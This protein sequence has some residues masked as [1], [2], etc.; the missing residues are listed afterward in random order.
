MRPRTPHP[1]DAEEVGRALSA[2]LACLFSSLAL[3]PLAGAQ[4]TVPRS[5]SA[6][7]DS[8]G[9]TTHIVYFDTSYG[10]WPRVVSV[11]ADLGIRHLRDGVYANPAPQWRD[12][13]QRYY[14][15]VEL[16][17]ARGLRFDFGMGQ[18]GFQ[19]GTLRQLVAVVAGRLRNAV[20]ALEDPNEFD[21][22]GGTAH[23]PSALAAY[24]RALY[25]RVKSVPSLRSLPVVGPSFALPA[26]PSLIGNQSPW[27]DVGNIHPYT[28][29]LP[30]SLA[31]TASEL[32]R[33]G[34]T[35]PR[36]PVWATEA[37]Y[38][39]AIGATTANGEETALPEDVAAVYTL[40]TLLDNFASGIRRTY[41]YELL[42]EHP[43]PA[44]VDPQQN[45]GLLHYDFMPKPAYYAVRNLLRLV[46]SGRPNHA[47]RPLDLRTDTAVRRLVLQRADGSYVVALW[48]LASAWNT[49]ARRRLS[50]PGTHLGLWL[51]RASRAAIA[52]PM[53]GTAQ[54]PLP[55]H[56]GRAGL[57]IGRDPILLFVDAR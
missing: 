54:T 53:R 8:V 42:D 28:G 56:N 40:R 11:L 1:D 13:N 48:T 52:D 44:R 49:T 38:S 5:A 31:H 34:V 35:A 32:V 10:D 23:W 24:D 30:P 39:N 43:D 21:L 50:V 12:W 26:S 6:F 16:A 2:L 33:A 25:E 3:T 4:P 20:E 15:A 29:G 14:D 36:K 27:L 37:G 22:F 55:L 17:A 46:G 9:V 47:L 41:L 7:Q 45:F 57:T 19:A 51:P 18:P